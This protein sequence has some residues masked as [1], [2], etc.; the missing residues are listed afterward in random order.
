MMKYD[1][2][3]SY[4]REGGAQYARILQLMLQQHGYRVFLDYDELTDG[5]F[6]DNIRAAIKAAPVFVLVLSKGALTRCLDADDWLRQEIMLAIEEGKHLIPVNPDNSFDGFPADTETKVLPRAIRESIGKHQF[7]EIGFGQ[8]LG[9][10]IDLM[11]SKRLVPTLGERQRHGRADADF[12][13]AAETLRR[14]D[15]HR[16]FMRRLG[17]AAASVAVL[18]VLATCVLFW[19]HKREREALDDLRTELHERHRVFGLQLSP[20][21]TVRQMMAVDTL[22]QNM[23][24]VRTDTLWMSQFEMSVGLWH[25]ILD[26]PT[27]ERQRL[28]PMTNVSYGDIAMFLFKLGDMTNLSVA[29]PSAEEWKYAAKGGTHA[30]PTLYAGSDEA[31]RVA[32]YAD[33]SDG[34]AHPCDGQQGKEPNMLDLYDMSGNV[35]ELCN[36]P[37]QEGADGAPFTVCGGHFGSA[38]SGVTVASRAP[39]DNNARA[40]TVG[41][42]IVISSRSP[43]Q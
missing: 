15:A 41:F 17:V 10:T 9:V 40:D 24:T 8:T 30:E 19:Q 23:A 22:L 20:E 18:M 16:R 7:S 4:R 34:H 14:Q 12:D 31:G 28:L 2:F 13:A 21:L 32:W 3:I 25:D 26:E 6:G 33:N 42:R 43:N 11:V 36:T 5:V 29:L 27:D 1:I 37:Y 38:A 35:A 39:F